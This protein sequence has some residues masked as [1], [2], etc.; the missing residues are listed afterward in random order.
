MSESFA[1]SLK[2]S[3]VFHGLDTVANVQ[4]NGRRLGPPFA[5]NMFVRYRY[6]VCDLLE[7]KVIKS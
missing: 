2:C 7:F 3:L 6:D 1:G 5:Q 4:L